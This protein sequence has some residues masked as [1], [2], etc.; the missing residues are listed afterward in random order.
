MVLALSFG[1]LHLALDD[2]RALGIEFGQF[3]VELALD[4]GELLVHLHLHLDALKQ[5]VL[6]CVDQLRVDH[7]AK[8]LLLL[9]QFVG[10]DSPRDKGRP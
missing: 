6:E 8:V 10:D 4:L 1:G 2:G 7:V 3:G 9:K 5:N